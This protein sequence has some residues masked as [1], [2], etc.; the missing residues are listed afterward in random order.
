VNAAIGSVFLED[1]EFLHDTVKIEVIITMIK[2]NLLN[3][4]VLPKYN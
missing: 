4:I 3:I 2:N 1:V